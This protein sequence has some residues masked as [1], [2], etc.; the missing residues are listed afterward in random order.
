MLVRCTGSESP[1]GNLRY[2]SIE[3]FQNCKR[4]TF[5]YVIW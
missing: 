1:E 2:L 4:D 5:L 3:E